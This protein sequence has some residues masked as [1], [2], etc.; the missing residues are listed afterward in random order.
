MSSHDA[1]HLEEC[2]KCNA[3]IDA[4]VTEC[5]ECGFNPRRD[6][7]VSGIAVGAVGTLMTALLFWTIVALFVSIPM[8]VLGPVIILWALISP[9]LPTTQ[10]P[11]AKPWYKKSVFTLWK[12]RRSS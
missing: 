8:M 12:E 5:P 10:D 1:V 4:T 6:L 9:P 3:E 7:L 2:N 11:A